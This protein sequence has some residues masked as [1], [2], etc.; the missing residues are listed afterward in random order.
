[1]LYYVISTDG[2]RY[3][4]GD[5][6]TLNVWIEEG[7]IARNTILVEESTGI[8][9]TAGNLGGL[10][11]PSPSPL[12]PEPQTASYTRPSQSAQNGDGTAE[13]TVSWILGV[14]GFLMC[15][16]LG[17][18]IGMIGMSFANR[19]RSKGAEAA[20]WPLGLNI[21]DMIFQVVALVAWFGFLQPLLREMMK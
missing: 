7:R 17:I 19:A 3:G 6:E 13:M 8:E 21:A 1:M 14:I 2:N 9:V 10:T 5:L 11:F 20:A 15:P 16:C 12:A 18:V 4:P